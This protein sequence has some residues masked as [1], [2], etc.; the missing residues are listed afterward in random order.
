MPDVTP[1]GP[2]CL[3][4]SSQRHFLDLAPSYLEFSAAQN[5]ALTRAGLGLGVPRQYVDGVHVVLSAYL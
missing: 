4:L 3:V 2:S 1:S 5:V